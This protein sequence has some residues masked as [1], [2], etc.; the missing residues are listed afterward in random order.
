MAKKGWRIKKKNRAA[1]A[2]PVVAAAVPKP[3]AA[4]TP[5]VVSSPEVLT[6]ARVAASP[7]AAP[8][9]VAPVATVLKRHESSHPL[10]DPRLRLDRADEQLRDL[11]REIRAYLG[12]KPYRVVGQRDPDGSQVIRAYVDRDP[13]ERFKVLIGEACHSLRVVLDQLANVLATPPTGDAPAGTEFPIFDNEL[14]FKTMDKKKGIPA[15][16]SGLYDIRGMDPKA[17]AVIEGLQPYHRRHDPD[18][19]ELWLLHRLDIVDKHQKGL[20]TG[21]ILEHA[22][23]G[24]NEMHGGAIYIDHVGGRMTSGPFQNGAEV[25][26]FSYTGGKLSMN[27]D[28]TFNVAFNPK[29]PASVARGAPVMSCLTGLRDYV[30]NIV[31]PQL[32]VFV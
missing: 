10:A 27:V 29:G 18:G 13:P 31:F 25:A 16:T 28:V 30:R 24:I 11:D 17:Q 9:P 5:P 6:P 12:G 32:E 15:R 7:V 21:T 22:S 19:H 14:L 1:T 8:T 4:R 2:L 20:V 26:R 3:Q 23:V